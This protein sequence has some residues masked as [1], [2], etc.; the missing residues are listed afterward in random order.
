MYICAVMLVCG[1]KISYG[2]VG[3]YMGCSEDCFELS[4][5]SLGLKGKLLGT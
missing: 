3:M 1:R 2:C 4:K 5:Y